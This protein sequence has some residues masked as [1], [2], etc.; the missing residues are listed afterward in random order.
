MGPSSVCGLEWCW[1]GFVMIPNEGSILRDRG[2]F[3]TFFQECWP[4][5]CVCCFSSVARGPYQLLRS[6]P[7]RPADSQLQCCP[8]QI[9]HEDCEL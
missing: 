8:C 3:R 2:I 7:K 9:D 1:N 5:R 4:G 6:E